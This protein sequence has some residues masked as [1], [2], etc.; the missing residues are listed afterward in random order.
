MSTDKIL[1]RVWERMSEIF[2]H[3]WTGTTGS[4]PTL[5]WTKA[6][7]DLTPE[8]IAHGIDHCIKSP[9]EWPPTPGIFRSFCRPAINYE[10]A[11]LVAAEQLSRRRSELPQAWVLPD[12]GIAGK[13]LFWAA[14]GMATDMLTTPY[15]AMQSRWKGSLDHA[16]ANEANLGDIPAMGP[17]IGRMTGGA[18]EA[19]NQALA[20]L[21]KRLGIG[22]AAA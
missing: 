21:R 22:R 15:K 3:R 14:S 18:T 6:L 12:S 4:K 19:G 7:A 10:A 13:C 2:G 1:A 8:E 11:F 20:D 9:M 16:I 17:R 5:M